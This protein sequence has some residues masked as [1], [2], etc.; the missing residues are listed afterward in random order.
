MYGAGGYDGNNLSGKTIQYML[1]NPTS[2]YIIIDSSDYSGNVEVELR[3]HEFSDFGTL[4]TTCTGLTVKYITA[5][6][7]TLCDGSFQFTLPEGTTFE[8]LSVIF[9]TAVTECKYAN[10]P[11]TFE[12]GKTYQVTMVNGCCAIGV[13]E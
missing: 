6:G 5:I 11:E 1:E 8:T 13:F 9:P 12:A 10:M 4:P 2:K 7:N 3:L